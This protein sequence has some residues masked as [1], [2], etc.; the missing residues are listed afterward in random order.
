M[1]IHWQPGPFEFKGDLAIKANPGRYKLALGIID[2]W[3]NEPAIG[4]ANNLTQK[5]EWT[6]LSSLVVTR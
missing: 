5:D 1:K 3:T 6:V 4:F 2:P